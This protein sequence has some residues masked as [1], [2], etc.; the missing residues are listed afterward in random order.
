M[1]GEGEKK[2]NVT[3]Q[4]HKIRERMDF[5]PSQNQKHQFIKYLDFV[6]LTEEGAIK[7]GIS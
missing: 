1:S 7:I 4:N 5:P 6:M 2:A 3:T